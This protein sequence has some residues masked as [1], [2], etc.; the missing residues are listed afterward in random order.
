[1]ELKKGYW[2]VGQEKYLDLEGKLW[3]VD[4]KTGIYSGE[5]G[6]LYKAGS[7]VPEEERIIE[8]SKDELGNDIYVIKDKNGR[9]YESGAETSIRPKK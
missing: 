4:P 2:E 7:S 1:V 9:I 3:D 5:G 8:H 6:K